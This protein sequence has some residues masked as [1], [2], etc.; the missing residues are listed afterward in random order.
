MNLL[1]GMSELGAIITADRATANDADFHKK[2]TLSVSECLVEERENLLRAQHGVFASFRDAELHHTL[3]GN[4]NLRASSGIAAHSSGAVD[5]HQF[6]QTRQGESI[7]G[8]LIS[9]LGDAVE[10]LSGLLLG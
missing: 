4:L 5:E 8:I 10:N 9:Q 2:G 7:L 3:G 6:A 1:P